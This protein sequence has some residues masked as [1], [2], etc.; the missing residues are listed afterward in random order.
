MVLLETS[1]SLLILASAQAILPIAL[2]ALLSHSSTHRFLAKLA[3]LRATALFLS[4]VT[5]AP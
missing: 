4:S 5:A 3:L 2:A 1:S